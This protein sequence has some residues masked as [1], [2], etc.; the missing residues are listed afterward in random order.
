MRNAVRGL[1]VVASLLG[2]AATSDANSII[3]GSFELPDCDVAGACSS[4]SWGLFE[5]IPGWTSPVGVIEIGEFSLYGVTGQ[6]GDQVLELDS[7]G[8]AT[9]AQ[10]VAGPGVF[11][12]SF[13]YADRNNALTETFD[14]YWNNAL[15]ASFNPAANPPSGVMQLFNTQVIAVAGNNELAFVSTGA[16]DSLGALIDDVQLNQVPD[17]GATALLLGVGV[18]GLARIRRMLL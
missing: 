8:N 16:G 9:V 14:V 17:G 5:S 2:S 13:L 12:L 6:H 3:N 1:V 10:V 11:Q 18:L 7:T 4:G 15:L